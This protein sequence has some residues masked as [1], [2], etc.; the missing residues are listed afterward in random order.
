MGNGVHF[1]SGDKV[2]FHSFSPEDSALVVK[3]KDLQM[4][5]AVDAAEGDS[6]ISVKRSIIVE[7]DVIVDVKGLTHVCLYAVGVLEVSPSDEG[8]D[9]ITISATIGVPV[10]ICAR[11]LRSSVKAVVHG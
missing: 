6:V 11:R 9:F 5:I 1:L 2:L 10:S 4:S 7:P 8:D 3:I